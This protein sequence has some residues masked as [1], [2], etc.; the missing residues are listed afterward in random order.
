MRTA[1]IRTALVLVLG[2]ISACGGRVADVAAGGPQA[3]SLDPAPASAVTAAGE[4]ET[5]EENPYP[6]APHVDCAAGLGCSLMH[7]FE[8]ICAT[9]KAV[10]PGDECDDRLITC[11]DG[12][13]CWTDSDYSFPRCAV[14]G[15]VGDACGDLAHVCGNGADHCDRAK[16][17]C[18]APGR[19]GEWCRVGDLDCDSG[20][21]CAATAASASTGTCA[22]PA[23]NGEPCSDFRDCATKVCR[24]GVCDA[25]G[26]PGATC[27]YSAD[28]ASG[29]CTGNDPGVCL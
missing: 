23:K 22:S 24:G 26:E 4:G 3:S 16:S 18:S 20:L 28:C 8:G 9:P 25:P 7:D 19:V 6:N 2:G 12:T 27:L 29:R 15:N 14:V 21:H 17:V 5:C 1:D 13:Q 11:A 10:G